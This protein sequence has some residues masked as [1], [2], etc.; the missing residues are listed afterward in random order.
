[1]GIFQREDVQL[2]FGEI[3]GCIQFMYQ[4]FDLGEHAVASDQEQGAATGIARDNHGFARPD[5]VELSEQLPDERQDAFGRDMLERDQA[6]GQL[7]AQL[8]F[9]E[10]L[11][12]RLQQREVTG[13]RA[14]DDAVR[15]RFRDTG[16][17]W[18]CDPRLT[19]LAARAVGPSFTRRRAA[20][21]RPPTPRLS[22][23]STLIGRWLAWHRL[24]LEQLVQHP[25]DHYW[26]G[27]FEGELTD[28]EVGGSERGGELGDQ[29]LDV[30]QLEGRP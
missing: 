22:R 10:L 2:D 1:L 26:V 4:G 17:L 28:F 5:G 11:D 9:V 3:G 21:S 24:G 6:V 25:R 8:V 16:D 12:D 30:V 23:L 27:F 13:P 29:R 19:A 7:A 18:S 14:N 15:P 20:V